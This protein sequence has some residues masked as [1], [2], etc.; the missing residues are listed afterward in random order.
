[1]N[2]D[3][4]AFVIP[5]EKI[6]T[7]EE[8]AAGSNTFVEDGI[9]YSSVIGKVQSGNGAVGVSPMA[10]EIKII[11]KDMLVMGVVTDD[12]KSVMFVEIGNIN[13]GG[14]DYLA[15]KDGKIVAPRPRPGGRFGGRES[16]G[17]EGGNRFSSERSEKPCGIGD[18]ILARVLYNDKDSYT[19]TLN[20]R[21]L[22][23]IFAKC[24]LC[25][26]DMEVKGENFL[27]CIECGHRQN[28]KLSELYNKA[29]EIRKL[30]A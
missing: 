11:G 27:A 1:M 24:E 12:M 10:R 19:L 14:K 3:K 25:G 4:D 26:S 6:A 21:E 30:F 7:E 29:S 20:G 15:L 17:H 13:M 2:L 5:G 8:F 9:I 28:K 16:Y 22:G 18:T 23:V